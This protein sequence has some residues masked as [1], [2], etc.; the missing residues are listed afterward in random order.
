MSQSQFVQTSPRHRPAAIANWLWSVALLVVIVIAV[1][2]I[3]RLTESGLSI[4][5]WRPVS[6]ILPPLNEGDWM[7]EFEKY[8]QIPE[9]K[10][11]NLG[12]SLD[13]FK[14]IFFWEWFHRILGRIIGGAMILPFAYFAWKRTIPAGYSL[15]IFALTALVGFQGAIGWW[16]VTSGLEYRTDVSHY[17]LATHLLTAL[18]LLAGLVWT[19]RDLQALAKKSDARPARLTGFGILTFVVVAVQLLLGAWVAGLNAGYVANTWPMMNDHF[20]PQGIDWT[21][22]AWMAI[23]NDPFLLH[24]LH[25][26]W[27][28]VAAAVVVVLALRLRRLGST[29]LSHGLLTVIS[30]QVMLG[31]VTVVSGM[32][33]WI[34][35]LHQFVGAILVALLAAS[36][37]REG[38]RNNP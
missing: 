10:E 29:A 6:G 9:Y 20:V 26:W 14:M 15:R 19:A 24:F 21:G 4:T 38:A 8:K 33:M 22:G 27:A 13:A 32:S 31:I 35:V 11:V 30:V 34:A 5:E 25:R 36:L 17:R 12:M 3:T 18:F 23:T 2:G 1:G 7:A 37:N 16:M 28:W